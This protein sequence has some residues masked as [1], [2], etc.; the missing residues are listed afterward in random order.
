MDHCT[1]TANSASRGGGV[2]LST[3][4]NAQ[5]RDSV[6]QGNTATY[7]GG[8][9]YSDGGSNTSIERCTIASNRL[10]SGS[11]T[12]NGGGIFVIG[13]A[14]LFV[15]DSTI[16]GNTA[17]NQGGGIFAGYGDVRITNST[18]SG[19]VARDIGGGVL[20]SAAAPRSAIGRSE[21][22]S[23]QWLC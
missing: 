18:I 16:N 5:I 17:I 12:A 20:I 7:F 19:N 10:V 22:I 23:D 13:N 3:A 1:V 4:V 8:G 11:G 2:F 21:S 9:I 15:Q 6:I 14:S